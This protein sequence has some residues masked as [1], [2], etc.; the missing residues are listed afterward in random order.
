M[1]RV[2]ISYPVLSRECRTSVCSHFEYNLETVH[3][4]MLKNLENS[5]SI[6][7]PNF[8]SVLLSV[9]VVALLS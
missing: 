5:Q 8:V 9:P 7:L 4:W 6:K 2:V 3:I 1:S